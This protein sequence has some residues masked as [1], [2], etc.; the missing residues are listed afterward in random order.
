MRCPFCAHLE[1]RV[2]DSRQSKT[3]DSIRRRRECLGC[4]RRFTTYERVE[5][6]FPQIVKQDASLEDYDRQ[7]IHKGI[8]LACSKR[9][10]SINQIDAVVDRVEEKL[11]EL[12]AREVSSDWIGSA[13]TGELRHFDPVAYIRFASVYRG[14]SDIEEFLKELKELGVEDLDGDV[15]PRAEEDEG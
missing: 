8:R 7:K 11:L 15:P 3:N 14:F 10:I 12:G 9:P 2:V 13:I 6:A 4:E 1:D 5:E